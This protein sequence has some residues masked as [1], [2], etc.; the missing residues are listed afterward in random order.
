M[1][2]QECLAGAEPAPPTRRLPLHL[3]L[4]GSELRRNACHRNGHGMVRGQKA[5]C[6]GRV[7]VGLL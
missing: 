7:W 1:K 3:V 2:R 4:M 6:A 5:L